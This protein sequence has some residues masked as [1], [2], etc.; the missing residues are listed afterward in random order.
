MSIN[1]DGK[2]ASVE[3]ADLRPNAVLA[4]GITGHRDI[5]IQTYTAFR[6]ERSIEFIFLTLSDALNKH[7]T[8]EFFSPKP[9]SVTVAS[10]GAAGAD[11]LAM[12]V[13]AR[14]RFDALYILPYSIDEFRRDFEASAY[15]DIFEDLVVKESSRFELP[16]MRDEGPRSYERANSVILAN[17]DVL[18]AVWD[19]ERA[20]GIGGTAE[21]V[22]QAF[23]LCIP[24]VV[25]DPNRPDDPSLLWKEMDDTQAKNVFDVVRRDFPKNDVREIIDAAINPPAEFLTEGILL[26]PLLASSVPKSFRP[27]YDLLLRL[28]GPQHSGTFKAGLDQSSTWAD[29]IKS[30]SFVD[31][32]W[33]AHRLVYVS[34]VHCRF[35]KL[36]SHYS[37]LHRSSNATT[38]FAAIVASVGSGIVGFFYPDAAA[39]ALL[40]QA[41]TAGL[42]FFDRWNRSQNLW[43]EKWLTYRCIAERLKML[44][45]LQPYG[46][47]VHLAVD[48]RRPLGLSAADWLVRRVSRA[49]GLPR[50][51]ISNEAVSVGFNQLAE[52]EIREQIDYHRLSYRRFGSLDRNLSLAA[53]CS[54]VGIIAV[55]VLPKLSTLVGLAAPPFV[56]K[57]LLSVILAA[58]PAMIAAFAGLRADTDLVRLLERSAW[59]S[60]YLGKL[61]RLI[62]QAARTYDEYAEFAHRTAR[63]LA[64]ELYE[65][66]AVLESRRLRLSRRRAFQ[67]HLVPFSIR[68]YTRMD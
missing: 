54:I 53:T 33:A 43:H 12:S 57:S 61:R 22:Q 36:S 29:A 4:I 34:R 14:L 40:I 51:R 50:G 2:A 1:A 24:I 38:Y 42:L 23:D 66:Q 67:R 52:R 60:A 68:K 44:R 41:V 26:P 30:A 49:I 6:I 18:I 28:F 5:G 8:R 39:E 32:S 17:S 19:G 46:I 45:F 31:A 20:R 16:G 58:L 15:A 63:V 48:L 7:L 35:D 56:A 47:F 21:V 65:W 9:P 25:V 27:E 62:S 59:A 55:S 10:M 13:A 64:A 3:L 37:K 11:L